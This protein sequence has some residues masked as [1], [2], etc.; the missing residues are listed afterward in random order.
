MRESP[1]EIANS[2]NC[3]MRICICPARLSCMVFA[4]SSAEPEEPS[5]ASAS[6]LKSSS[7]EL[8]M[9]SSPDIPCLPANIAA[10]CA[11]V[12]PVASSAEPTRLST[13][14]AYSSSDRVPSSNWLSNSASAAFCSSVMSFSPE[15]PSRS[16]PMTSRSES[17]FPS[18]SV[19]ETPNCSMAADILSVGFAMLVRTVL[20][21]VPP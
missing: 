13:A 17:I 4:M 14:S 12:A 2:C 7:E 11:L 10:V 5:I 21:A 16:C 6:L 8:T 15:K 3:D 18:S 1:R 9:A 19:R 20:S